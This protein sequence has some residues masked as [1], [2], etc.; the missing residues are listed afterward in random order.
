[1]N[2]DAITV[3]LRPRTDWEA[4]DLG[5]ALGRRYFRKLWLLWLF[6]GLP[7]LLLALLL[8]RAG[9]AWGVLL[10]WW[11]TPLC[12]PPLLFWLSRSLFGDQPTLSGMLRR[13][14]RTVL[15]S[16]AANLTWRRLHPERSFLMP[17]LLLEGLS[18][19]RRKERVRVLARGQGGAFWLTV[20]CFFLQV[21]LT[22]AILIVASRLVPEEFRYGI[23][24]E[25]L[26]WSEDTR[27]LAAVFLSASLLGPLYVASGFMLYISRRVELEAWDVEL[28][29]R[30]MA[31]R[32]GEARD[33]NLSRLAGALLFLALAWPMVSPARAAQPPVPDPG[34]ARKIVAEVVA[35]PEF[36]H[37]ETVYTWKRIRQQKQEEEIGWLCRMLRLFGR[38]LESLHGLA[39]DLLQGWIRP[40]AIFCRVFLWGAA[41]ALVAWLVYRLGPG[42]GWLGVRTGRQA[43]G[44]ERAPEV[45]FGMRM[46]PESLPDDLLA[47][48]RDL[49]DRGRPRQALALLY[50][51]TLS[52]LIHDRGLAIAAS[53]T[54]VE[55]LHLVRQR[56]GPDEA[57]CFGRLTSIWLRTAYGHVRPSR[58]GLEELFT[59]WSRTFSEQ[60]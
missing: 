43:A 58:Q 57:A 38:A 55:C 47:A 9:A 7:L 16:L 29:F 26:L 36:G 23:G 1:M 30:R 41:G 51:G 28:G 17:I 27:L 2:L 24:A 40:L 46:T 60:S 44:P 19:Q 8:S 20:L 59:I 42:R 53:A 25:S 14:P 49:L 54:E 12:E 39:S 31:S 56:R 33:R 50:R 10:L 13:W 15:P 3:R 37:S 45:L 32:L 48:C 11:C 34:R 52:R 5:F 18:G 4:M 22:V 6:T 21:I 35:A